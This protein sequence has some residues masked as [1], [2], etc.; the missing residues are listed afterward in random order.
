MRAQEVRAVL[1]ARA[2]EEA[3]GQGA[4]LS[5]RERAETTRA[6]EARSGSGQHLLAQRAEA[7]LERT[8]SRVL[9]VERAISLGV[10]DVPW[11]G[12]LLVGA[13]V[14][15]LATAALGRGRFVHLLQAP[16]L[17]LIVLNVAIYVLLALRKTGLVRGPVDAVRGLLVGG[18]SRAV[19][20]AA[21]RVGGAPDGRAAVTADAFRRYAG[22]WMRAAAP[23]LTSRAERTLHAGALL[24]MLGAIG[25]MYLRGL[26]H[27]FVVVWE[28]TFL[29]AG[30]VE[31][32][33]RVVLAPGL[34]VLDG[35]VAPIEPLRMRPGFAGAPAARWAHLYAISA[36]VWVIVPRAI[37][38]WLASR[39]G[40][41]LIRDLPLDLSEPYYRRLLAG[42]RGQS[43]HVQVLPY[44]HTPEARARDRL[45]GLLRDVFG[46]RAV[47]STSPPVPYGEDP[48]EVSE[49]A[50][51]VAVMNLAQ[52]P[53]QEVHGAFLQRLR[54]RA[55]E[56]AP[57]LVLVDGSPY[58]D[59]LGGGDDAE[60]RL[61]E[62]RVTWTR[63]VQDVGLTVV[64]VDLSEPATDVELQDAVAGLWPAGSAA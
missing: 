53:E 11:R 35:D 3:D 23:L 42:G 33:L 56:H 7:L 34:A 37:L 5:S 44:S 47:S 55:D 50:A 24:L 61:G 17:L 30:Q 14:L 48:P 27:E 13:L 40:D 32:L 41:Q 57:L 58:R 36:V 49:G 21:N 28:S 25:S 38:A 6:A 22:H 59:R 39:R 10:T 1:L 62:R 60:R 29:D 18:A 31:A 64:H 26:A 46:G 63:V 19:R 20:A 4:V 51:V 16:I 9:G 8:A 54:D 45:A 52:T 43:V 15:G 12:A 2:F